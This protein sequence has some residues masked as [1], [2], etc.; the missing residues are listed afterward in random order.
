MNRRVDAHQHFWRYSPEEYAWIAAKSVLA[1]TYLPRDLKPL[2]AAAGIA[3]SIVVQARQTDA[4]TRWLLE[5]ADENPWIMG[6]VG[7]IDLRASDLD[8]RIGNLIRHGK[9]LGVRHV[10]Q[11]EPDPDFLLDA[12]FQRGV[13]EVLR[14]GLAY[15]LLVRAPQLNH[16]PAFL[17]AVANGP[18]ATRIVIDHGAKPAIALGEWEPWA[19]RLAAIARR[20]PVVCKLSGLATEADH[21][22]WKDDEVMRYMRHLLDCFGPERLIFGSD[23]PVCLL[24]GTYE[25]VHAL[26]QQFLEPLAACEREA[27]MGGNARRVYARIEAPVQGEAI[28]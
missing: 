22:A 11:D 3:E 10:V 4:E 9:L 28:P 1:E 8:A 20:Y 2:L 24:A 26:V 15:E 14:A 12:A 6:V 13:S 19:G 18:E 23:W 25:R 5:L 17:D 7:W 21:G 27:I 16:V